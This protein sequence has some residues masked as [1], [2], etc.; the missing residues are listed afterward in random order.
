MAETISLSNEWKRP[1]YSWLTF[2]LFWCALIVV[3]GAYVTTPLL[4]VFESEFQVS[5]TMSA[6]TSSSFSF[7]Y[8]IGFLLF[9]PLSDR[10]GRK[11]VILIGLLSLAITTPLIGL[12]TSFSVLVILRGLQGFV[13]STFAPSALAYVFDVFPSNRLITTIGFISFGYVTSGIFGQVLADLLYQW[14]SWKT[15]FFLFGFLYFMT[16]IAASIYFPTPAKSGEKEGIRYYVINSK[17]IFSERNFILIYF[18]TITLLLTFMGMY[19]LLGDFFSHEPFQLNEKQILGV[20]ALGIV[21]MII[22][23]FAGKIVNKLGVLVTLRTGIGLSALGLFLL[24][25]GNHILFLVGMSIVYV[26]GISITFPSIMVLIGELG[27]NIRALVNTYYAF[28]LFI[29]AMLGPIIAISLLSI[30]TYFTTFLILS[31]LLVGSFLLSLKI[32]I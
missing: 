14:A 22:S 28:I 9:G 29:G 6:W 13:A 27:G 17:K 20:R 18:I 11:T 7:F 8:A 31:L 32:K 23:P 10:I 3:S 15:V 5:K 21:G 16:F 4:H 2:M 25:G 26:M 1:P 24:G 12:S 19:T 30:G